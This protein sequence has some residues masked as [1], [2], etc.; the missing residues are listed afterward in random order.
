[1]SLFNNGNLNIVEN[2]E[3]IAA[4]LTKRQLALTIGNV[5]ANLEDQVNLSPRPFAR[6][7]SHITDAAGKLSSWFG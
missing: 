3:Y 1:M 6:K 4:P 2:R 5:I 7:S